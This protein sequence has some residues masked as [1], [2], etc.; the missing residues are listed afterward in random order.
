MRR[1][2]T[3]HDV[4]IDGVPYRL[5]SLDELAWLTRFAVQFKGITLLHPRH[6][7]A[8]LAEE[9]ATIPRGAWPRRR[10]W[11]LGQ[12]ALPGLTRGGRRGEDGYEA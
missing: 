5:H 4:R 11:C 12:L 3:I 6:T 10:P 7:S 1:D 2:D 9:S 8:R